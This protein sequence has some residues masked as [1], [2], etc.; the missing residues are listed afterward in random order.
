MRI[1]IKLEELIDNGKW[2]I[3]QKYVLLLCAIVVIL[4]GLDILAIGLA[5]PDILDDWQIGKNELAPAI[6]AGLFGM[7][8]GATLGG[9]LG[10]RIGR[11]LALVASVFVF[12]ALTLSMIT[13]ADVLTLGVLRFIAGLGL[14]SALPNATA[15]VTEITPAKHRALGVAVVITCVPI[16]GVLAGVIGAAVLP[17][18]GWK[19]LFV[20]AGLLPIVVGLILAFSLPESPGFLAHDETRWPRLRAILA[21]MGHKI[22]ASSSFEIS[23]SAA[24]ADSEKLSIL[25]RSYIRDTTALWLAFFCCLTA[26]YFSYNW[27][28]TL[29]A[30]LGHDLTITS[31]ALTLFNVGGILAAV[32]GGWLFARLGSKITMSLLA[33]VGIAIT[34]FL[35]LVPSV[36]E[37]S[38]GLLTSVIAIQGA[39][40]LGLQ[41]LLYPLAANVYPTAIRATGVGT[42]AGL[43]RI[44]AVV[45]AN[46]GAALLSLN[47]TISFFAAVLACIFF[48]AVGILA[49]SRQMSAVITPKPVTKI[50]ES[51]AR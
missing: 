51:I 3:F 4:D 15:L 30:E 12:G 35:V 46:V 5:A 41:V 18:Y 44:G 34:A 28:P 21:R 31:N 48:T 24:H 7:M 37:T 20:V 13:A 39:A 29:L 32:T 38:G 23:S 47:G 11:R 1:A 42:A 36:L 19:G 2:S 49:V 40:I 50:T 43:G 33:A 17:D 25:S 6:A 9:M 8:I 10:D 26:T 45:S 22:E 27:I 16:G 14:G